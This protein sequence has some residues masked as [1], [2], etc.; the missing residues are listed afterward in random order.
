MNAIRQN[1]AAEGDIPS[2]VLKPL[3]F[4]DGSLEVPFK[5]VYAGFEW[6]KDA[7]ESWPENKIAE[8]VIRNTK[9]QDVLAVYNFIRI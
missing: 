6:Q 5:M 1:Y 9:S 3:Q 4:Y 2:E 7:K 8:T